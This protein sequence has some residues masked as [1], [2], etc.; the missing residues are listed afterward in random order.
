MKRS[1]RL[2][3]GTALILAA[4]VQVAGAADPRPLRILRV[5]P[6]GEDV[7][8]G[9]PIVLQFDR[10]VV[11]VGRMERGADEIPI[12]I[13]PDPGCEWR[14]INTS[15]LA[16]QLGENNA[17]VPSTRY[18]LIAR[19]GILAEDGGTL[20]AEHRHTFITQRPK[21]IHSWFHTWKSPATPYVRL[22][23]NQEVRQPSAR[24][25]L[26][27]RLSNGALHPVR[28]SQQEGWSANRW[29]VAPDGELPLDEQVALVVRPGIEPVKGNAPSVEDREIVVFR[30]FPEHRFLGIECVDK[31]GSW[32][33]LNASEQQTPDTGCDPLGQVRLIFS[34]PVIKEILRDHLVVDPDT[35]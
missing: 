3:L 7:P 18:E 21:V 1:V 19:P 24:E 34:S 26:A 5:N 25:H 31:Q 9:Q 10:P 32:Q 6:G 33:M 16:C 20:A 15:A 11:P 12:E 35:G 2:S 30:T 13:T 8:A 17:L 23:F 4:I 14:W 27:F 28:L 29:L 22:T